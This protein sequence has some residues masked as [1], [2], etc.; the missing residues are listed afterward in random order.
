METQKNR[1]L[2]LINPFFKE[3]EKGRYS[4][5]VSE[6]PLPLG[7]IGTYI[8]NNSQCEVEI[9]DPIPQ[10]LNINQVLKKVEVADYVALTSY[11]YTRFQCFDFARRLKEVN[12]NCKL[13]VGGPHANVLDEKIIQYYPFVDAVCRGEGENTILE[14]INGNPLK[15]VQGITWMNDGKIVRNPDR[16]FIE[17][18]DNLYCDFSLLPDFNKYL[19]DIQ[20]PK[21]IRSLKTAYL[22][23][24]RGCPFNCAFCGSARWKSVYRAMTAEKIVEQI[25]HL[26]NV[27]QIEYI[28]FH[29]DLFFSINKKEILK[30]CELLKE[31]KIDIKF[32]I[33]SRVDTISIETFKLLKE[34]GCAAVC[35]GIESGSDQVLQRLNKRTSIDKILKAIDI[36]NK[37]D[38]WK[39]GF[40]MVGL[41]G[42]KEEDYQKTLKLAE[43]FE[44]ATCSSLSIYP[45]TPLYQELKK[46]GEI[47]DDLW[48]DPNA[49]RKLFYS[50]ERFLG[51]EWTTEEIINHEKYFGRHHTFHYPQAVIKRYGL[52]KGYLSISEEAMDALFHGNLKGLHWQLKEKIKYVL[53]N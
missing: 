46:K 23:F 51:A 36:L 49:P 13:I 7:F 2:L 26:V 52:V 38:Y 6:P 47:D 27:H 34:V 40:F 3:D 22:V 21:E 15:D 32:S 5:Q 8:K 1:K 16:P 30:F 53:G 20:V 19:S 29:D 4:Y 14:I 31:K 11:T 41:P 50:K 44:Y 10:R 43:K 18:I 48:F 37:L 42:E 25:E 17:N 35:M 9:I 45:G 12:P 39:I 24:S 33:A 28:K